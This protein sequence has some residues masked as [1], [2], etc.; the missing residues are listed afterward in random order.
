MPL[1]PKTEGVRGIVHHIL[2]KLSINSVTGPISSEKNHQKG[3]SADTFLGAKNHLKV[4]K[5]AQ[6]EWA[7]LFFHHIL[8][9]YIILGGYSSKKGEK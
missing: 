9:L 2:P 4:P 6:T 7:H 5:K 3:S 8:P 1:N